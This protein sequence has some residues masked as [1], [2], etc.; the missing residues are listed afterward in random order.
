M[1]KRQTLYF[2]AP[3]RVE[4]REQALPVPA[5][6]QLLVETVVSAI[7]SG[8][9]MLVYRGQFPKMAVDASIAS[10]ACE[11]V[12]PLAYGYAAVGRVTQAGAGL[13][14]DWLGRLVFSFQP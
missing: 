11:F 10:L 2:T 14:S 3:G 1:K 5:A 7:S 6:G 12:Y 4:V 13:P 9:E 8:T